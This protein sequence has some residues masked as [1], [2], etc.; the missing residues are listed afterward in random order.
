MSTYIAN[1]GGT[2][3]L[4]QQNESWWTKS[5]VSRRRA[6]VVDFVVDGAKSRRKK[7]FVGVTLVKFCTT[8]I[9]SVSEGLGPKTEMSSHH[10]ELDLSPEYLFIYLGNS[11]RAQYTSSRNGS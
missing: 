10:A 11:P 2:R 1:D 5:T 6:D 7:T 8:R 3:K 4:P 9:I